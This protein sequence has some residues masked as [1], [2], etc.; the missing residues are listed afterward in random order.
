MESDSSQA[1]SCSS[2]TGTK[3]FVGSFDHFNDFVTF[4]RDHMPNNSSRTSHERTY[5]KHNVLNKHKTTIETRYCKGHQLIINSA[6]KVKIPCEVEFT[7][8]KCKSCSK[9]EIFQT[10]FHSNGCNDFSEKVNSVEDDTELDAD[11]LILHNEAAS[12]GISPPVITK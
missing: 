3:K 6:D 11:Q 1:S 12:H 2:R 7:C 9:Y 8:Y 5:C 10:H 4:L